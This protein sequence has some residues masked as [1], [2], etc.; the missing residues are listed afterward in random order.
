MKTVWVITYN[1]G[2][3]ARVA[4]SIDKAFELCH[5]EILELYCNDDEEYVRAFN[6][7]IES[8]KKAKENDYYRFGS[9]DIVEAR[10][11]DFYED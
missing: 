9:D 6:E 7:L 3:E 5:D 11:A 4:N 1:F 2:S 8:F 10:R